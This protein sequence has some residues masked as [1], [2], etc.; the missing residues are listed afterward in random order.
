MGAGLPA[1]AVVQALSLVAD[2]PS[3]QASQ[4]PHWFVVC[5]EFPAW[6]SSPCGSGLARDGSSTGTI[7][8]G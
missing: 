2:I 3:S 7:F 6:S 8:G 1:M 4:L 5:P